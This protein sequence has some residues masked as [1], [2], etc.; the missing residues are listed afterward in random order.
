MDLSLN[1]IQDFVELPSD[2]DGQ[3]LGEKLTMHTAEVEEVKSQAKAYDKMVLG[4][5]KKVWKHPDADRLNLVLVDIGQ[6]EPVQIVCGGQ[7]LK[8]GMKVAAALPGAEV[9]FHGEGDPIIMKEAKI[10]GESSHGMICAGEEIG[11][12]PD[13]TEAH[14]KE[15]RIKDLSHLAHPAGTALAE[16]LGKK[17]TLLDIDNKSITHRPD[18]WGHYGFARELSVLYKSPLKPLEEFLYDGPFPKENLVKVDIQDEHLCPRFTT[19]LI[20]NVH[21][22]DSPAWLRARL[23]AA[24]LNPINNIVDVTNYVMLELGQPMHAYDRD[25][26]GGQELIVRY[27][28]AG[29]KLVALDGEEYQLHEEDPLVCNHKGEPLG[30]AGIK[31]GL[32]S[33]I[34]ADT[35]TVLLE[36]AHWDPIVVRKASTR[37]GLRTDA[38]QRFEKGLD[39]SL[40]ELAIRRALKLIQELCPDAKITS[41]MNT[42]G[43]WKA[44]KNKISLSP[45]DVRR[46]V[47]VDIP[48]DT[49]F[50]ILSSLGF[51]ID[52]SKKTWN[53]EVPSH[54]SGGD[55]NLPEDLIEEVARIYG[56]GNIP[57]L[58]PELS[59]KHPIDN[60]KRRSEHLTRRIMALNLGFT[61][62]M[63][64]SFYSE[65]LFR[66]CGFDE[67]QHIKVANYLSEDQTHMRQ[68][69]VPNMLLKARE[70]THHFD[71]IALFEL[72]RNYR[73]QGDYM[74][75]ETLCLAAVVSQ[76]SKKPVF[77]EL[78]AKL[79]AYLD[80][81]QM[82]SFKLM[83]CKKPKP[84]AHPKQ[85]LDIV[86]RGKAIGQIYTLHPATLSALE[87]DHA[88]AAFELKFDALVQEGTQL[89]RFEEPSR[90]PGME[91]DISVLVE[92]QE[93]VE[94]LE[95]AI[96]SAD[97]EKLIHHLEVFDIYEGKNLPEGQKSVSFELKLQRKDRTL[98][99]EEFQGLQEAAFL[100]LQS[101]GGTIRG[102]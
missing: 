95:K 64:Y 88:V 25:Q 20:E 81:I 31:G 100:A 46:K 52:S 32:K 30:I 17:D 38:S 79:E 43:S 44:P 36:A 11:L 78:K 77:H 51:D 24:G 48:D 8:E 49:M 89:N 62:L 75:E 57:A 54:R 71:D 19:C 18:L 1:W 39:P 45:N 90:F 47:G 53:V 10:R 67:N 59:I 83:P 15:V 102:L 74:P 3:E 34:Q 7:N 22:E 87:L 98:T 9:L 70:N 42:Q 56:Y 4:V 12:E 99:D 29:E 28:K 41:A 96:R 97:K 84:M 61:E 73:D 35:Q 60:P 68:S 63:T 16:A 2:L 14:P 21:I 5:V 26:V 86:L 85:C 66:A 101:Q 82:G 50:S 23:E 92:S 93:K 33:G 91:L 76:K 13:N 80:Q 65:E 27:A 37:I 94:T 55:V 6:K 40:T 69:L 58:V 72:G